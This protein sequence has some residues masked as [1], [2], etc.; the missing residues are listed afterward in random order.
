MLDNKKEVMSEFWI[1]KGSSID[2]AANT[3]NHTTFRC[4]DEKHD[5]EIK[6]LVNSNLINNETTMLDLGCGTGR[7]CQHFYKDVKKVVGVD[8]GAGFISRL[9]LWKENESVSNVDFFVLDFWEKDFYKKFNDTFNLVLIY[10]ATIY[11]SD[12]NDYINILTNLYK[13]IAPKG[14][15]II[16]QTTSIVDKDVYVDSYIAEEKDSKRYIAYYHTPE[17]IISFAN[18]SGFRFIKSHPAYDKFLIGEDLY[19]KIER[20]PNTRQMYFYFVRR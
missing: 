19:Y 4:G 18:R 10:G 7:I 1:S 9:N 3:Y 17:N 16:K 11:V 2:D 5:L 14:S 13:V 8:I 12:D 15:L 20:W 6:E